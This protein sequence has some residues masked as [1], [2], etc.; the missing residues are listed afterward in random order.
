MYF[1]TQRSI[2][3]DS[4]RREQ[5]IFTE[6]AMESTFRQ[7]GVFVTRNDTLLMTGPGHSVSGER[8]RSR[9]RG[10]WC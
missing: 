3:T 10:L 7:F 1:A 9:M 5:M 6:N 4:P 2:Q 8:E